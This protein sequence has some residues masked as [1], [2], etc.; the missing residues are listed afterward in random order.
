MAGFTVATPG[1]APSVSPNSSCALAWPPSRSLRSDCYRS[2]RRRRSRRRESNR[3]RSLR[4][5]ID[6]CRVVADALFAARW[7]RCGEEAGTGVESRPVSVPSQGAIVSTLHMTKCSSSLVLS[8]RLVLL[9]VGALAPNGIAETLKPPPTRTD[10]YVEVLHGVEIVDPYRWLEDQSAPETREWIKSQS[11]YT[12]AL[13]DNLPQRGAIEKRL[14]ELRRVDV[15]GVPRERN[16]AY[17]IWNKRASDDL[18][19]LYVRQGL[20]GKDE[21]L[22]DPHT[23]SADHTTTAQDW[24]ISQDGKLMAYVVRVGGEDEV[25]VRVM[26]VATRKDLP[27]RL[28]RALYRGLSLKK[29]NSG[30][31]YALQNRDTGIRIRYHAM[32]T[33]P[34]QD[35]EV[36]GQSF[37]K[38]TWVGA[39]VSEDG[40]HLLL[41]AQH[42]W[43]RN[44]VYVQDIAAGGPI[45]TIVND[46]DAHFDCEFAGDHLIMKTDWQ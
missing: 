22:L 11:E 45:R 46:L 27:D 17:F 6:P 33:D 35:A 8:C 14:T 3:T 36:F 18:S 37:G 24:D 25:E 26:D 19:I 9:G 29:D 31:Y 4:R 32:G 39:S 40:R 21:V 23:L 38:D 5:S 44:E 28:P 16:G 41:T 13:L 30:F 7:F 43:A 12:H 15:L 20:K 10:N 34:S 42:G 1:K 2:R